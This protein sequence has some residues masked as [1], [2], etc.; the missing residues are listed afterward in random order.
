MQKDPIGYLDHR[1]TAG[2]HGPIV[3]GQPPVPQRNFNI[4]AFGARGDGSTDNTTIIQQQIDRCSA[5]GGGKV[6]IPAGKFLTGTLYLKNDVTLYLEDGAWL[7]GSPQLKDY[8]VN[9]ASTTPGSDRRSLLFA[10]GA[11]HIAVTGNGTIDGQGGSP[12]FKRGDNGNGRPRLIYF[13]DCEDVKVQDITLR[14][15]AFWVQYYRGCNNVTIR[16][17]KVY[18]HANWNNDGL[19]IDSRNVIV[20]D[21]I[22]DSDDDALCFK[23]ESNFP[24]ENITVTNC[25]LSSNCNAIKMGTASK[26]G[27]KHIAISNCI[28]KTASEDNIRHWKTTLSNITADRTVLSGIALEMVDGGIMDG[29]NISNIDMTDVQTPVFIR[30][31]SRS[32]NK[33]AS[34]QHVPS[35]LKNIQISH[36]NAIAQSQISCSITGIPGARVENITAG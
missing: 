26:V 27:F 36:I 12:D 21:C 29:I 11:R 22:I 30:L 20:S 2:I 24:C 8:P 1:R 4:E 17:I 25:I 28:V 18:S 14:Q 15:A 6:I 32:R 33:D 23:S 35:S 10:E 19:D 7:L 31:G 9:T 5:N 34:G 13:I 16:G 3:A